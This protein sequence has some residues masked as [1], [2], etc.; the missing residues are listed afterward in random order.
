MYQAAIWF[1]QW[2]YSKRQNNMNQLTQDQQSAWDDFFAFLMNDEKYYLLYGKPG[3]G[4]TFLV[5]KI[6]AEMFNIY[7]T[8]CSAMDLPVEYEH[9]EFCAT[10]N[11]AAE[12]LERSLNVP[13]RTIHSYL[14]LNVKKDYE[15]GKTF[16]VQTHPKSISRTVVFIDEASMIDQEMFNYIHKSTPNSKVVFI[17]DAAQLSPVGSDISP[18]FEHVSED[19]RYFLTQPVRNV[20]SPPLMNLCDQ[21]RDTVETGNFHPISSVP[22][23]ITYLSSSE[24]QSTLQDYFVNDS[25]DARILCYSNS[26]VQLF[27]ASIR[28]MQ[29]RPDNYE[30]GEVLVAAR[31]YFRKPIQLSVEREMTVL[32]VEESPRSGGYASYTPDKKEIPFLRYSVL[33]SSNGSQIELDVPCDFSYA[34]QTLANIKRKKDWP[35]FFQFMDKFADVRPRFAST[36]YKAQGS[37]YDTSFIDLGNIGTCRDPKQVARMLFVAASRARNKV[38]LFGQLPGRYMKENY[39][40][41][42]NN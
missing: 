40:W 21:L 7:K 25:K 31:N 38:Y 17:G 41:T 1:V 20:D 5:G 26:R 23:T 24:M 3:V 6:A 9:A 13:V 2:M 11:K 32:D 29:G 22:G 4:K 34:E 27:N 35:M 36:V 14:S 12:V 19:S 37:T 18:I 28:E 16:L 42:E 15:K 39:Q 30:P 10:T 8:A 33:L